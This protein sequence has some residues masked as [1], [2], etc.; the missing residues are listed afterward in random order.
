[1]STP[2]KIMSTPRLRPGTHARLASIG[3]GRWR[4]LDDHGLIVGHVEARL[5]PQGTRFAA[6]RYHS[7]T[8][9][10]LE[11]GAFWSIQ[12]AVESLLR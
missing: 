6:R 3:A 12:D 10:F 11:R 9:A 8:R 2:A 1:M 7:A 4:V 5:D